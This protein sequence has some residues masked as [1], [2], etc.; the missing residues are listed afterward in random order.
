MS[1]NVSPNFGANFPPGTVGAESLSIALI[2]PERTKRRTM[3]AALAENRRAN[4]SEFESYPARPEE[5]RWLQEQSFDVIVLDLDSDPDVVLDLVERI[6]AND[7]ANVMLYSEQAD[8][9][10]AVRYMRAGASEY[11][12]LPLEEGIVSEALDRAA[13]L[14]SEKTHPAAQTAGKLLVFVCAKGGCGV[15]TLSCNLAI[16]LASNADQKTLLIDFALPIGDAALA[17]GITAKYSTEDAL[18]NAD[19]LDGRLLKDLLVRHKS[20]VYVLAAPSNIPGAEG[21]GDAIDKMIS[22]ARREFDY[23]IVDVGSRMDL[24]GTSVFKQA[25]T[26]YLVTLTGVSELR[27]SNRLIS[28]FFPAGGPNLEVVVN[29]FESRLLGGVNEDVVTKALGRPVRWKVPEDKE[30]ARELQFGETG[31]SETRVSRLSQEIAG[32][33]TGRAVSQE[34]KKSVPVKGTARGAAEDETAVEESQNAGAAHQAAAQS[35]PT[36]TWPVPAPITYGDALSPA[37][38]NAVASAAGTFTYQPA[39]GAVLPAGTHKLSVIFTPSDGDSYTTAQG[40]VQLTVEKATPVVAWPKPDPI[41]YGTALGS[42][43]LSAMASVPGKF[44]YSAGLGVVLAAGTH[45]LSVKFNPTD[46]E[47]YAKIQVSVSLTV[48]KAT[49]VIAWPAPKPIDSGTRLNTRQL[50]ATASV[51]GKFDYSPA[52]GEALAAGTHTLSVAFTPTDTENYATVEAT[53]PLVVEMATPV[54]SWPRPEPITF[55][56][57]LTEEQLCATASVPGKFEY[58]PA[59]GEVLGAGM[60]TLVATFTPADGDKYSTTRSKVPLKVLKATPSIEWPTLK[61]ALFG[62]RLNNTHLCA[63]ASVPGEFA[64]SPAPGVV[65]AAGTHK[66][67]VTFTPADSANYNNAQATVPLTVVAKARPVIAWSNP[68]P[69]PYGTPIGD[70][71]LSASASVTGTFAYSVEPGKVLSAG[72]HTI[73]VTFT[74]SDSLSYNN[75]QASVTLKVEKAVPVID[76]PAPEPILDGTLLSAAQLCATASVPGRFDYSPLPGVALPPGTHTLS[77]IFTPSDRANYAATQATVR[78][79]VGS[80]AMPEIVWPSPA[81]VPYGTILGSEQ[82]C[83][84]A[85][86]PGRFEYSPGSGV[87]LP[88]GTHTLSVTFFPSD[89]ANYSVAQSTVSLDVVVK[90]APVITWPNP[91]PIPYGTPLGSAQLCASASVEGTFDYSA[92]PGEVLAA[93]THRLSVTFT[94][95]DTASYATAQS[96]VS[97]KVEKATPNIDWPTP[98]PIKFGTPLSGLQLDAAAWVPGSF[99][100]SPSADEVLTPGTHTLSVTFTPADN[101]N[102]HTAEATVTLKVV[103]RSMPV[104]NWP[105]PDPIVYG[106]ALSAAQLCATSSVPGTFNY[107]PA[108]GEVLAPGMH[109]L[110]VT[111]LP[112]DTEKYKPAQSTV[113]LQ[114]K[115]SAAEA[116]RLQPIPV[117]EKTAAPVPVEQPTPVSRRFENTEAASEAP[118]TPDWLNVAEEIRSRQIKSEAEAEGKRKPAQ[119]KWMIAV[120]ACVVVLLPV[121]VIPIVHSR[122]KAPARDTAVAVAPMPVPASETQL[123]PD[124]MKPSPVPAA[125]SSRQSTQQP[126]QQAAQNNQSSQDN[127]DQQTATNQSAAPSQVQSQMM[128]SQLTAPSRISQNSQNR[129]TVNAPPPGSIATSGMGGG[130]AINNVFSGSNGPHVVAAPAAPSGPLDISSAVAMGMLAHRAV[131]VYPEIAKQAGVSGTVRLAVTISKSG[132][133]ESVRVIS[134]PAMLRQ[135]A[136]DAVRRW[137]Y[138]PYRINNEPVE[139]KTM[140]SLAFSM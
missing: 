11:L 109:K 16:A 7:S 127:Q 120:G 66:L 82:L 105:K 57:E 62:S 25:S 126:A 59:L 13:A 83:A 91:D 92:E 42:A 132:S 20:G 46:A 87:E 64:Y 78:L 1:S 108:R 111:F 136:V 33:V 51:P 44:E 99:V 134:G 9:K 26:V 63:T 61:P 14:L 39:L 69:I 10:V 2:G 41:P 81:P 85:S 40:T 98:Q 53:V 67:S 75:A 60:H 138:H 23:V 54:I 130:G 47:N 100:Y 110:S 124:Q 21:R 50:C 55:G 129:S 73:S 74:P 22:V 88:A 135:A 118:A 90:P 35:T 106:A 128:N 121:L 84:T 117:P 31:E 86:V 115:T 119:K 4:V 36:I 97:L 56:D 133:I 103:D 68:D 24:S 27:N 80:K 12:L 125:P 58:A 3:A 17:L 93:G 8:T 123:A 101:A 37:Q 6:R 107:S 43:Q 76:W 70:D 116:S 112:A 131:P 122:A 34:K 5:F 52:P 49:P 79:T 30:T 104:I 38:L 94:P 89:A 29:R 15:T 139:V 114:V 113:A 77:A 32:V 18:R 45:K 48:T 19:R 72:T 65:L 140:V 71:Q 96:S 102:Y 137:R 95:A 28:Q